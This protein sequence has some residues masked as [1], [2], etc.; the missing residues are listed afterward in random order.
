MSGQCFARGSGQQ[1]EGLDNGALRTINSR[2]DLETRGPF[3][4]TVLLV[5]LDFDWTSS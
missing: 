4:V 3:G 1:K 2:Y 5:L